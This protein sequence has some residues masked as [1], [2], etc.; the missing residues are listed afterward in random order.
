MLYKVVK[1]ETFRWKLVLGE[2]EWQGKRSRALRNMNKDRV[3]DS[4]FI[5]YA[6]KQV[7]IVALA[8]NQANRQSSAR[9]QKQTCCFCCISIS[10]GKATPQYPIL[11]WIPT[12]TYEPTHTN[13][14]YKVRECG[15]LVAG[16]V[17]QTKKF[18]LTLTESG[19]AQ[20]TL[21]FLHNHNIILLTH[22]RLTNTCTLIC[23]TL[24]LS[25][26]SSYISKRVRAG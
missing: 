19:H 10:S 12:C 13:N 24:D 6:N 16:D 1:R 14:V 9:Q 4:V 8:P 23:C 2:N 5:T 18:H 22:Q 3:R 17:I 25:Q 11:L 15:N 26:R 20:L 7:F 21:V